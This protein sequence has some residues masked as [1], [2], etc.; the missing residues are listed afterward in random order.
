MRTELISVVLI[1]LV[2]LA[3]VGILIVRDAG[4]DEAM[5][6]AH[7]PRLQCATGDVRVGGS[8]G[9]WAPTPEDARDAVRRSRP[10][11]PQSGFSPYSFNKVSTVYWHR[12]DDSR[13]DTTI[14]VRFSAAHQLWSVK[15][16]QRCEHS[17]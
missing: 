16:M 13:I 14:T 6:D 2:V 5:P 1:V 7:A 8:N 17:R 15:E 12:L 3:I 9:L 10:S 4:A 11:L